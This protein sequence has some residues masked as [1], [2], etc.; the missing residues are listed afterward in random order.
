MAYYNI[1][2]YILESYNGTEVF[3]SI[4]IS[5]KKKSFVKFFYRLL[6]IIDKGYELILT[7]LDGI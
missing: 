5:K 7:A 6:C 1:K 4:L 3:F 2:G